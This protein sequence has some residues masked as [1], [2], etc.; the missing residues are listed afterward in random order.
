MKKFIY[1]VL[2]LAISQSILAEDKPQDLGIMNIVGVSPIGDSHIAAEKLPTTVQ[3]VSSQQLDDAKTISLSEYINRFLGS[4]HV[5]EA[6]NNPLQPDI[7]YRGFT[8]SPLMGLPQ[9]LSTYVNGVRFNEPFGDTVNWDLIPQGAIDSMALY[10]SN[11]VYGLN[12]LGGAIAIKTKTGFSSPKHQV[13]VYGGS[14]GRHSEEL[15]SGWNNG[16]W[17]YFVDINHFQEDGWRDFSPTKANR[18]FGTLSWRG[19][20]GS[21]DLTLGSND[22]DLRGNGPAPIQ[23]LAQ[24]RHAVFTQYDQT[25]TRMFFSE[26]SGSYDVTNNI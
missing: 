14:F 10:S 24:N 3:T 18:A 5:N 22:N 2:T 11:P 16:T 1:G 6:Q 12:S 25:I 13:E 4:A 15:T 17:G 26:L 21:L 20:K 19:D 7:S 23:L 9:G 8:A